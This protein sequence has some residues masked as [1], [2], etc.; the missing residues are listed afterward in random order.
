V[1]GHRPRKTP[2]H[3]WTCAGT[4]PLAEALALARS[5]PLGCPRLTGMNR[6]KRTLPWKPVS[7]AMRQLPA[8]DASSRARGCVSPRARLRRRNPPGWRDTFGVVPPPE[9]TNP[10]PNRSHQARP[11]DWTPSTSTRGGAYRLRNRPG[12]LLHGHAM[13]GP[14][15]DNDL[16]GPG[17]PSTRSVPG[18]RGSCRRGP[19]W[20]GRR[21]PPVTVGSRGPITLPKGSGESVA[22]RLVG[23]GE[24]GRP[25]P[26]GNR[27]RG[28]GPRLLARR[29]P[30]GRRRERSCPGQ[31]GGRV[32]GDCA[33]GIFFNPPDALPPCGAGPEANVQKRPVSTSGGSLD[34]PG[35]T[36]VGLLPRKPSLEERAGG[37]ERGVTDTVT[38]PSPETGGRA[39]GGAA[40]AMLRSATTVRGDSPPRRTGVSVPCS[41]GQCPRGEPGEMRL[42]ERCRPCRPAAPSLRACPCIRSRPGRVYCCSS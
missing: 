15:D 36:R 19:P 3:R 2:L 9:M 38:G 37:G 33:T 42:E 12:H 18:P 4:G 41:A 35:D 39:S 13:I 16:H 20:H 14:V 27:S 21:R 22:D 25:L 30:P 34:H 10:K 40:C 11:C 29:V 1:S 24:G 28:E 8:T 32:G 6:R 7:P 23:R 31:P 26:G 5:S 17:V